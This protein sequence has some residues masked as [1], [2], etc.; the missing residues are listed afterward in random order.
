MAERKTALTCHISQF[1]VI[2]SMIFRADEAH[3]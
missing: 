2:G 1:S 3:S